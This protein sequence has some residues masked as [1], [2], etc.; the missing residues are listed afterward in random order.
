M[1]SHTFLSVTH[2]CPVV[3]KCLTLSRHNVIYERPLKGTKHNSVTHTV[4]IQTSGEPWMEWYSL[5]EVKLGRR[6][7]SVD[8][9]LSD[10]SLINFDTLGPNMIVFSHKYDEIIHNRI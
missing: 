2:L 8:S 5:M 9:D 6:C 4:N 10:E 1:T 7:I 3:T